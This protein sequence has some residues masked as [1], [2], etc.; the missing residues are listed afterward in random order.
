MAFVQRAGQYDLIGDHVIL[1]LHVLQAGLFGQVQERL[2]P[3]HVAAARYCLWGGVGRGV[4]R[5]RGRN[6]GQLRPARGIACC[7]AADRNGVLQFLHQAPVSAQTELLQ[8][9]P[10]LKAD[11]A[12][13]EED[14]VFDQHPAAAVGMADPVD[15]VEDVSVQMDAA[16]GQIGID[17]TAAEESRAVDVV[18]IVVAEFMP[19]E[20]PISAG[21]SRPR[22]RSPGRCG[23]TRRIR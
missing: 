19:G 16:A 11:A 15:V 8:L 23:R 2:A 14:V 3:A 7:R 22:R 12:G 10:H 17:D 6:P 1:D 13:V 9:V 20:G 5:L 18:E 4:D 21:R